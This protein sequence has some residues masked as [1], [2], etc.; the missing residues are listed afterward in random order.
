MKQHLT[1]YKTFYRGGA[2]SSMPHNLTA[3]DIIAYETNELGNRIIIE[4]AID[5]SKTPSSHLMWLTEKADDAKQYG[6]VSQIQLRNYKIVAHDDSGGVL[7]D[8]RPIGKEVRM[9]G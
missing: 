3:K 4:K 7:V 9:N 5:L 6:K 2:E 8:T 1:S